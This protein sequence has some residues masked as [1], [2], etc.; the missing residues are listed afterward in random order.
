MFKH[1]KVFLVDKNK[2]GL[3]IHKL[4]TGQAT[5]RDKKMLEEYWDSALSD[6]FIVDEMSTASLEKLKNEMFHDIKVRL[7]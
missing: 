1:V 4:K 6:T 2:I 5:D 3:L 7:K